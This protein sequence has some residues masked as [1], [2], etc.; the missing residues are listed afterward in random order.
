MLD[1]FPGARRTCGSSCRGSGFHSPLF[2]Q[3]NLSRVAPQSFEGVV[4]ANILLENV[5]DHVTKVHD[6]PLG[7]RGS[8]SA[9]RPVTLRCEHIAHVV[10]HG[11]R[12]TLRFPGT[13]DQIVGNRGQCGDMQDENIGGFFVQ[14]GA[15][16]RE[17]FG[18]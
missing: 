7:G 10:R 9:E 12:L 2:R 13:D 15:C 4:F 11:P 1:P 6:D 17:S 5:D 16:H 3:S 14:D 18:L 8:F